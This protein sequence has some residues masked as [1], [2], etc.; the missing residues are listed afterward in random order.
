MIDLMALKS[1]EPF[2]RKIDVKRFPFSYYSNI[3]EANIELK[4]ILR[5]LSDDG[6]AYAIPHEGYIYF[7]GDDR[8]VLK[9]VKNF[10]HIKEFSEDIENYILEPTINP[11]H[12]HIA[13]M[14]FYIALKS[15]YRHNLIRVPILRGREAIL[16]PKQS[17]LILS[18]RTVRSGI[19]KP[20]VRCYIG[21]RVKLEIRQS[22]Y[23]VLWY[24][25][26]ATAVK[27]NK[28][29]SSHELRNLGLLKEFR[30]LSIPSPKDRHKRTSEYFLK[31][32]GSSDRIKVDFKE[33]GEVNFVKFS[34]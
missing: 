14:Q 13:R 8:K 25:T 9:A 2:F 10:E 29:L 24:D 22:G 15:T 7:L 30:E 27:D 3:K 12:Y 4:N 26:V 21:L 1:G 5:R 23:G 17:S 19:A 32:F 31:V 20:S 16:I 33:A 28:R 18:L 34:V 11:T 6:Y